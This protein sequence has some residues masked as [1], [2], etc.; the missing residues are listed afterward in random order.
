MLFSKAHLTGID[1]IIFFVGSYKQYKDC[2]YF[3]YDQCNKP[4]LISLNIKNVSVIPYM[5]SCVKC[6]S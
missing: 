1:L 3:E 2:P 4:V 5:V 6:L